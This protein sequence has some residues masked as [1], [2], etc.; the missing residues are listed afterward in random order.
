[1]EAIEKL[2]VGLGL[3]STLSD[4]VAAAEDDLDDLENAAEK[5][6][7]K[8]AQ[9]FQKVGAAAK[10]IGKDLT[11]FVTAP[12]LAF[13]ALSTQAAGDAAETQ[14]K[15]EQVFQ[16]MTADAEAWAESYGDAAGRATTDLQDMLA[17]TMSIV[18]AMGMGYSEGTEFS[19]TLTQLSVDLA[20]FNNTAD[21]EAF[22]ALRSAITGEYEALKRYGIVV[23]E[24]K[25]QQ[26]LLNMGVK[27]G[28]KAA[29]DAE[30][31]QARMN[32]ILRATTDAQ[33]DAERTAESFSNQEKALAAD[34]K[35][36][37]ETVGRDLL[38]IAKSGI[39]IVRQMINGYERL[40]DSTRTVILITGGFAAALGPA[41][42]L[43]GSMVSAIGQIRLAI[44]AYKVS[45]FAATLA[46][47]GFSAALLTTPAGMVAL[48]VAGLVAAL[49]ALTWW[50]GRAEEK[51]FDMSDAMAYS[52]DDLRE[53]ADEARNARYPFQDLLDTIG[54]RGAESASAIEK[55]G[56]KA[57]WLT[58]PLMGLAPAIDTV[59]GIADAWWNSGEAARDAE[60]DA[61]D[62]AATL[63]DAMDAAEDELRNADRAYADH[64]RVVSELGREY[65]ELKA[66]IDRAMEM[67]E[68]IDDQSR[69]IEHA[70][71]ALE[72]ARERQR[73]LGPDAT[74]L[75]RR[76]ADLAIRDAQDRLDDAR[77]RLSDLE[78][79]QDEI[80]GGRTIAQAQ[81]RLSELQEQKD[82]ETALMETALEDRNNL[83]AIYDAIA[84]QND[85]DLHQ[86]YKDRWAALKTYFDQNPI[87]RD[88]GVDLGWFG[89]KTGSV[90]GLASGG[91][92][93]KPTLALVGEAGPEAIVPLRG[94]GNSTTSIGGDT[95]SIGQ[96]I[97][98]NDQDLDEIFRRWE[99]MQRSKRVRRGVRA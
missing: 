20:S 44:E 31:A 56:R 34:M 27:G 86:G 49:A 89:G 79:E 24:A 36:L 57:V 48:G 51:A 94:G 28:T 61:L 47:R 98:R 35:E 21:S 8:I 50:M 38:P 80:L 9:D 1:M 53:M 60:A 7:A 40:D 65:D 32:I 85:E 30:K 69:A 52:A 17:T 6:A 23:N 66:A 72:R 83:Q 88:I 25:V 43:A 78:A 41:I 87:L 45:T 4:D 39:D 63:R 76:E 15:F 67:P 95:L 99:E 29:T 70:Q 3:K 75:D 55:V 84:E 64:Q 19:E 42:W 11:L 2:F 12:L 90:P 5:T 92:V 74:S 18:K 93:T 26:E 96:V 68:D 13:G 22:T 62:Y 33:G 91:V 46:T 73:N 97:V 82:E 81:A 58:G 77:K 16:G 14:S 59:E 37:G 54:T 71:I 10:Q